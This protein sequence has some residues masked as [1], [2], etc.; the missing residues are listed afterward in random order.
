MA[1]RQRR[2]EIRVFLLLDELSSQTDEP[3]L[4]KALVFQA[5]GNPPSPL[6]LSVVA[7]PL[8]LYLSYTSRL[9]A[10]LSCQRLLETRAMRGIL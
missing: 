7:V 2:F 5:P 9:R 1:A 6:L 3:H 8:G 4:P 10:G